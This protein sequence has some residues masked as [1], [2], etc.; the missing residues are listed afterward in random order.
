MLILQALVDIGYSGSRRDAERTAYKN[1]V[2]HDLAVLY[3]FVAK[4]HLNGE[5]S[6][7]TL[8]NRASTRLFRPVEDYSLYDLSRLDGPLP[9]IRFRG[10]DCGRVEAF[11]DGKGV[12][13]LESPASLPE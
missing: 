11:V 7:R 1:M 3:S 8:A 10:D 12:V 9:L 13:I 5:P 4:H 2:K 6:L